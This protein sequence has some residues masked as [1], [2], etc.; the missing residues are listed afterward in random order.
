LCDSLNQQ[1]LPHNPLVNAGAIA[2]C[3]LIMPEDEPSNRFEF[4]KA[5]LERLCGGFGAIGFDN[6]YVGVCLGTW[7][8]L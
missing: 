1:G 4:L 7:H 6:G 8:L 5:F 3:S 2:M